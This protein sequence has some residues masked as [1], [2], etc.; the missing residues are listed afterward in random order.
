V[1]LF[2]GSGMRA[3]VWAR[4]ID[5]FGPVGVLEFYAS[6][7][8]NVVLANAS[9]EKIGALG[10]PLPGSAE[11]ALV[12]Y[13]LDALDFARDDNGKY[14]R[15]GDDET[16]MLIARVDRTPPRATKRLRR[17]V[18][19]EDDTWFFSGD[20]LRRDA[21]GDYWFVD[22]LE[23]MIATETGPV[24]T[25]RIEDVLHE[26]AAIEL[27]VAYGV[28]LPEAAWSVPVATIKLRDGAV[29]DG[30]A[31]RE[32]VDARLE[33]A[34]RPRYLRCVGE[35]AM[36]DGFRPLKSSLRKAGVDPNSEDDLVL[37]YENGYEAGERES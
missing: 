5:R 21:D 3:D 15:C 22:R 11:I 26:V 2:A 25:V 31:L 23:N 28:K 37:L 32:L 34:A 1:R 14:V 9:G 7:E 36:T 33:P 35:I 12:A 29:L 16:G 20:L 6:T 4:L 17:G 8:G 19:E 27:A 18:F 10:R 13:D 30:S 24:S